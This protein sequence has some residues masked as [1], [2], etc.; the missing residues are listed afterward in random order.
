MASKVV[1]RLF[2]S[3][4]DLEQSVIIAKKVLSSKD[5]IPL[6]ILRRV[7][8][9]EEI[10]VKQRILAKKLCSHIVGNDWDEVSRHVK[11]INGLSLMIHEDAKSL[12]R[13]IVKEVDYED[14]RIEAV[15]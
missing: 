2:R 5:P 12:V 15:L 3:L 8:N 11:L 10:L 14:T 9:Y 4:D 6:D 1:K 7:S 13:Q